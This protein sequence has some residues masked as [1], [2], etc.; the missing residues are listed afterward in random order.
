LTDGRLQ[1]SARAA[2]DGAALGPP[3]LLYDGVRDVRLTYLSRGTWTPTW[4]GDEQAELPDAVRLNMTLEN[5]GELTQLFIV[6][7]ERT[8]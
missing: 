1:R 6:P 3:Q 8:P 2:L 5:V 4:S 7:A